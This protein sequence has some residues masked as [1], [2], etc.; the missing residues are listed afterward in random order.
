MKT[1]TLTLFQYQNA[2]TTYYVSATEYRLTDGSVQFRV[3]VVNNGESYVVK[4]AAR[5]EAMQIAESAIAD[6]VRDMAQV[7]LP[8]A[9]VNM[10]TRSKPVF[11]V[12]VVSGTTP[13]GHNVVLAAYRPEDV[14]DVDPLIEGHDQPVWLWFE[15]TQAMAS[16]FWMGDRTFCFTTAEA[17]IE[18]DNYL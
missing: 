2:A 13:K 11:P 12:L 17:L 15:E 1:E 10:P 6:F 4:P 7:Y 18:A 9:G 8:G 3:S 16:L 14:S 5:S